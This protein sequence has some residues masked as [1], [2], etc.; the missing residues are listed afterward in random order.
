MPVAYHEHDHLDNKKPGMQEIVRWTR[1]TSI[2][3]YDNH[4]NKKPSMHVL[5]GE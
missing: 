5:S 4:N 1:D 2:C 3:M